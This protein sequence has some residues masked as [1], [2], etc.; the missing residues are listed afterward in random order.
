M[1]GRVKGKVA[2]VSG[3]A[4]G[5]GRATAGLLAL[6][7]P[8]RQPYPHDNAPVQPLRRLTG[9]NPQVVRGQDDLAEERQQRANERQHRGDKE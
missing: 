5:I 7:V 9:T 3:G 2:L 8:S 4:S 6:C 1:P